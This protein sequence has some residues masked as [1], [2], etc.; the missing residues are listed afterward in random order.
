MVWI[1]VTDII[2][3]HFTVL[4][5]VFNWNKL[6]LH[7]RNI[8]INKNSIPEL[9]CTAEEILCAELSS[10]MHFGTCLYTFRSKSAEF[11]FSYTCDLLK[12][13][14][15]ILSPEN[16]D[17]IPIIHSSFTL[18]PHYLVAAHIADSCRFDG[19]I[20]WSL[21]FPVWELFLEH[22]SLAFFLFQRDWLDPMIFIS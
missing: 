5:K 7:S 2:P 8:S 15:V 16:L 6:C 9:I 12:L 19:I 11:S 1:S 4:L 21:H 17:C 18:L 22:F 13:F 14:R 3:I 10:P 20:R